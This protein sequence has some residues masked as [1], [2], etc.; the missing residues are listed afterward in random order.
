[1]TFAAY[2]SIARLIHNEGSIAELA[3]EIKRLNAQAH[4]VL[5]V[6]G[7]RI[8]A[9][10]ILEKCAT[11]VSRAGLD[12]GVFAKVENDPSFENAAACIEFAREF[13]PEVIIGLGGGSSLDIAKLTS[14][15][16]TNPGPL[17]RYVGME[18]LEKPGIPLILIPTTAGTGSEVTSIAVLSHT[19]GQVKKGIVSRH[20]LAGAVILDPELT[21]GLPPHITAMTGMDALVHAI[22]SYTGKRATPFTDTWNLEAIRRIGANLR[23]AYH[24]GQDGPARK[25]MLYASCMAGMAFSNT[26]NGLDHA[27]A[28]AIGGRFHLPHGLL[29]AFLLPWVIG[30]NLE[31]NPDKF[32]QIAGA[33]GENITGLSERAAA[34]LAVKAA[35]NLLADLNISTKLSAYNVPKTAFPDL[36]KMTLGAVRLI[37]NNPREVSEGDVLRLL[38]ENY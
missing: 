38:E 22:E 33:L 14:A 13:A 17:D 37:S 34:R 26:Q 11:L 9:T 20:L 15:L 29:T 36:A 10:G 28:L 4:R 19:A 12:V 7:A 35:E 3:G 1:M 8:E 23:Q 5:I 18:L 30:F 6:C 31:A 21:W 2:N 16:L 24:N 32:A 25:N 27:M